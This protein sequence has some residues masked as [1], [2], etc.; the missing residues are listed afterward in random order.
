MFHRGGGDA[1]QGANS[2]VHWHKG[3]V[4]RISLADASF[5]YGQIL[6][7][8]DAYGTICALFNR[9]DEYPTDDV[10][11]IVQ[12]R[13]W[14]VVCIGSEPIATG[15]WPIIGQMPLVVSHS[16]LP[17][18]QREWSR[19]YRILPEIAQ[20]LLGLMDWESRLSECLRPGARPPRN[21]VDSVP[22]ADPVP[23]VI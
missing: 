15:S 12:S 5:A 9:H 4:F 11:S 3:E 14:A 16:V 10:T 21:P 8:V 22:L 6:H 18:P 17:K 2:G 7:R 13:V 23:A 1:L 20:G 19:H